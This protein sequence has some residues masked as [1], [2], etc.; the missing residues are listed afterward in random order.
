MTY[1]L[2]ATCS[3]GLEHPL[4]EELATCGATNIVTKQGV[5]AFN[6]DLTALYQC[7]LN[8]YTASRILLHLD[9]QPALDAQ[10]ISQVA[11]DIDW[12]MLLRPGCSL[13]VQF[14]GQSKSIRNTLFGAQAVKDGIVASLAD[15]GVARP[16]ID[17][18]H[19]D[20]WIRARLHRDR[21]SLSLDLI[22]GSLHQRG[23]RLDKGKAPLRETLAAGIIRRTGWLQQT[24][25]IMVD[26][27]CGSGTLLIEAALMA[28][29]ACPAVHRDYWG[30]MAWR[31]HDPQ[32]WQTLRD[33]A[34]S[35]Q[36][37]AP[38]HP[39]LRG[40]D[41]DR[42][43]IAK[44]RE[45]AER[46]GISDWI[47]FEV[48]AIERLA[49][50]KATRHVV[51]N[52]PYG[53]RLGNEA[54]VIGLYRQFGHLLRQQLTGTT[55]LITA[56][57]Q[58]LPL[59]GLRAANRWQVYNGA[60]ACELM[61]YQVTAR[62]DAQLV[63]LSKEAQGFSNRVSKNAKAIRKWA[64]SVPTDAFRVYDADMPEYK[65]AVDIY[66][67]DVVVSEYAP[68][69]TIDADR[70]R[71]RLYDVLAAL[72]DVLDV[73]AGH[74]FLKSRARQR[75][76]QQYQK[77]DKAEQWREVSEYG[78]DFAVNLSDY[79]DTGLFLDH[80]ITRHLLAGLTASTQR[81]LNLFCYTGTATVHAIAGGA[82]ETVSVDMSRT[83]LDWAERNL[84]LNKMMDAYHHHL[85][86]ADC[87]QF[88]ER[89]NQT[90]DVVFCDPPTFSNSKRM[91]NTLDIQRDHVQLL[92]LIRARLSAQGVVLFSNNL[93]SFKLD[94]EAVAALGYHIEDW[95]KKTLPQ[96]FARN[97]RI[98]H[99]WKLTAC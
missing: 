48:L 93:R 82:K 20:I 49:L 34:L 64:R 75:G 92:A 27:M 8:T 10:Q 95:T 1:S 21:L 13:A 36:L 61:Q 74:I 98:H 60:L 50:P 78:L 76:E 53:V 44:A 7:C 23:Y 28:S 97:P 58:L 47:H 14:E 81:V 11:A 35:Q 86:Q 43:V 99:C 24:Q 94:H 6:A 4:S 69:K 77:L 79:L 16:E 68:P 87:L 45:N 26:P 66:G 80:R 31:G 30:F 52:P 56:D 85:I 57:A 37:P 88:L 41:A 62:D 32:Q 18:K 25:E 2:L 46:A 59:L 19:P 5:V 54:E 84:R 65:V 29:R 12:S 17:P 83:Y 71:D 15:A 42:R 51:V 90:Y 39:P 89:D 55:T 72:P 96:D 40:Y 91:K 63:W 33:A 38:E 22:G 9:E 3:L 70:A 67:D 73:P